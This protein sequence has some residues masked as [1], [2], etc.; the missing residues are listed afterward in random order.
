[1]GRWDA[2]AAA[3]PADFSQRRYAVVEAHRCQGRIVAGIQR[4][5]LTAK[6]GVGTKLPRA[7]ADG[8]RRCPIGET[9]VREVGHRAVGRIARTVEVVALEQRDFLRCGK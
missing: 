7:A 9:D 1:P 6:K 2:T 8:Q 4:D 3:M 5:A